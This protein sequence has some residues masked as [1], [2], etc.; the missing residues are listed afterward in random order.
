[1]RLWKEQKGQDLTEYALLLLLIMLMLIAS[2]RSLSQA[3]DNA[4]AGV[5]NSVAAATTAASGGK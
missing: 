2:T 3:I 5:T 4:F 1:V